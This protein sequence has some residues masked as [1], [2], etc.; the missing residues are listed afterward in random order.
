ML[1]F[2]Y[3]GGQELYDK[4]ETLHTHKDGFE[5]VISLPKFSS[6]SQL[7]KEMSTPSNNGQGADSGDQLLAPDLNHLDT[8]ID[9]N[10]DHIDEE[11]D[12]TDKHDFYSLNSQASTFDYDTTKHAARKASKELQV[13]AKQYNISKKVVKQCKIDA[14]QLRNFKSIFD[15]IDIDSSNSIEAEEILTLLKRIGD[16]LSRE[17]LI[18]LMS[19][20]DLDGSGELE[21]SEFLVMMAGSLSL[22]FNK[23]DLLEAFQFFSHNHKNRNIINV[24][25]L[26]FAL[27]MLHPVTSHGYNPKKNPLHVLSQKYTQ[28]SD[29]KPNANDGNGDQEDDGDNVLDETV[30]RAD[31][32]ELLDVFDVDVDGNVNIEVFLDHVM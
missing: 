22:Q 25:D 12:A 4:L 30:K 11:Y 28:Y 14:Q 27:T 7:I 5:D 16:P 17:E 9:S 8:S 10:M 29:N 15:Y 32:N 18:S 20:V 19:K 31:I 3:L 21:F 23:K 13:L 1:L 6:T 26:R 24:E 2:C